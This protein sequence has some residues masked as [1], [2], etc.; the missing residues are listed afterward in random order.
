M[1]LY[2]G[3]WAPGKSEWAT[4]KSDSTEERGILRKWKVTESKEEMRI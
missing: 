3:E 2:D 4:G 1:C